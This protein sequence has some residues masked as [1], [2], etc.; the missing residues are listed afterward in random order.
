MRKL[1]FLHQPK[2]GGT[3][4]IKALTRQLGKEQVF[5]DR[6]PELDQAGNREV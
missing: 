1:I 6:A 4:L 3:T 2:T 5:Y